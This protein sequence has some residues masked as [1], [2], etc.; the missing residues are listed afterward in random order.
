M[1]DFFS[2]DSIILHNEYLRIK[3]L[4]YSILEKSIKGIKGKGVT[5]ILR[6]RLNKAEKSEILQLLPEI[7]LHDIFFDSFTDC[8]YCNIDSPGNRYKS[9]YGL[10]NDIYREAMSISHGFVTVS[11]CRGE[12]NVSASENY[13]ELLQYEMPILSVDVCEHAYFYDYR[14]DK[15]RYLL[16]ALPYL[17][18]SKI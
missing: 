13:V 2:E 1:T 11:L 6:M 16:N 10:L 17:N 7:I 5:D 9:S 18:L 8:K 4:K 14:F 12:I 3:K 15:E